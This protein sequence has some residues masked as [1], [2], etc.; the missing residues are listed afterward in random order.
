MSVLESLFT[1]IFLIA[2]GDL[3]FLMFLII[4]PVIGYLAGRYYKIWLAIS[5]L[6]Y[7]F[8]LAI[9]RI[10]LM[11]IIYDTLFTTLE[12]LVIV[13]DIIVSRIL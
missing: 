11:I 6:T 10:A 8:I 7:I 12:I 13:V 9:I 1:F 3:K 2:P 5:Y 4:I